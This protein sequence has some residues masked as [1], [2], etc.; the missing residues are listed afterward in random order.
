M[1][2]SAYNEAARAIV[3][4][5]GL[6]PDSDAGA[7]PVEQ[8]ATQLQIADLDLGIVGP[9]IAGDL[10]KQNIDLLA[11]IEEAQ[12]HSGHAILARIHQL[13]STN[14]D[15]IEAALGITQGGAT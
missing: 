1:D 5:F 4:E 10:A 9:E 14:I 13:V 2:L 7:F 15:R 8:I 6:D 12:G 3:R 11:V